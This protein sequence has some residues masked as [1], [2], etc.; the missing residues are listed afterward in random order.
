[1]TIPESAYADDCD[2]Y[3]NELL[4]ELNQCAE[5]GL[6]VTMVKPLFLAAADLPRG[7][8]KSD[9]ADALFRW[10]QSAPT[11]ADYP[12]NEPSTLPQIRAL[13]RQFAPN[14]T[15]ILSDRDLEKKIRGAWTGRICGCF[16]GKALEGIRSEELNTF[17]TM[18]GNYPM[19][20]YALSADLTQT[21][22]DAVRFELR[23]KPYA[24]TVDCAPADDDTNYTVLAQ[25]IIERYGR[26]FTGEDVLKSWLQ[27][28]PASAY[29][30]AE[31]VAYRNRTAGILPPFSAQFK[32]P[33]REWIGAQIR[34]DYYGYICPGDPEKAAEYAFRDASVSHTK[35]GVYSEMFVSAML[36]SAA[37]TDDLADVIRCGLAQ[38]PETSRLHVRLNE[39]LCG[40][41]DG[42]CAEECFSRIH[43]LYDEHTGY[44]WCHTIPNA[45]IVTAAL[46]YGGG[47]FA[48]SI[49]MAVQSAFDTD[50]NGATVGSV[51]GMARGIDAI[52]PKWYAPFHGVLTTQIAGMQS[53]E[54]ESLV[55]TTIKHI[56]DVII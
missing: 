20:R 44:G 45:M 25:C 49:C 47:D 6:D 43:K 12:Y 53:V 4:N 16:L 24:D 17:L 35:N 39:V 37:V 55:Q 34:G 3:A 40:Y 51:L 2:L 21:V 56:K 5:E 52:D 42:V 7:K 11:I 10:A 19:H 13:R 29:F 54:I 22:C 46:L 23:N 32:N 50:C 30:T 26:C 31:Q 38:I 36:A 8:L 27:L 1:M 28:Q 14:K 48:K 18:T 41:K 33:F 15:H 9:V